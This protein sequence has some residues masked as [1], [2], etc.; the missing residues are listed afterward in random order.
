VTREDALDVHQ[1]IQ[2]EV[3]VLVVVEHCNLLVSQKQC[4][5]FSQLVAHG[6]L[7]DHVSCQML[8]LEL[9]VV[10]TPAFLGEVLSILYYLRHVQTILD[11]IEV[12]FELSLN[13][14]EH[15][16]PVFYSAFVIF[17]CGCSRA[18][19]LQRGKCYFLLLGISLLSIVFDSQGWV[20]H[21][22]AQQFCLLLAHFMPA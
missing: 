3:I 8:S 17:G 15:A 13:L 6:C 7:K 14:L 5:H 19:S 20:V 12:A 22:R 9:A 1:G 4:L 11:V 18:R 2:F 10:D 21:H 16:Q